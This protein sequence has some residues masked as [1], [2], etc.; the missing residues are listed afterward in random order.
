MT[1]PEFF[2]FQTRKWRR[3]QWVAA[4]AAAPLQTLTLTLLLIQRRRE[5]KRKRRRKRGNRR[6]KNQA[7]MFIIRKQFY[8]RWEG[9]YLTLWDWRF[10]RQSSW[11]C[12]AVLLGKVIVVL[13]GYDAFIFR[14][15][16]SSVKS[17]FYGPSSCIFLHFMNLLYSSVLTPI[18]TWFLV[19]YIIFRWSAQ[20]PKIRVLLGVGKM[21]SS[22]AK[23]HLIP[24]IIIMLNHLAIWISI[25]WMLFVSGRKGNP[26]PHE[27]SVAECSKCSHNSLCC[28]QSCIWQSLLI[29]SIYYL[30]LYKK[31]SCILMAK[32]EHI[33]MYRSLATFNPRPTVDVIC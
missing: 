21:Q 30:S 19:S 5:R 26:V 28:L 31:F 6:K 16:Q 11:E 23:H 14:V 4:A 25:A 27:T 32:H 29:N 13:K 3:S 22:T 24:M 17:C 9:Y 15:R 7:G 33:C 18:R 10:S 12:E 8:M 20:K 1:E 2:F